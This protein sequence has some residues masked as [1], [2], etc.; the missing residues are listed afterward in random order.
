MGLV[1]GLGC[2]G[3]TATEADPVAEG[4]ER[5][6]PAARATPTASA[7]PSSGDGCS[8]VWYLDPA[9]GADAL[10]CLQ[11]DGTEVTTDCEACALRD[12]T[13]F[14]ELPG[15][16][17]ERSALDGTHHRFAASHTCFAACC[18]RDQLTPLPTPATSAAAGR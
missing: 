6:E 2:A 16:T 5:T 9:R 15:E 13:C 11:P 12:G 1:V 14:A 18:A 8:T 4:G 17:V 3:P 10:T 7:A